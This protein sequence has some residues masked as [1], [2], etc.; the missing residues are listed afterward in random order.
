MTD[1]PAEWIQRAASML[2]S[3]RHVVALTGAGISTPSGI[4]DF[5]S[6]GTGEWAHVDPME[7]VSLSTFRRR[8]ERFYAWLRPLAVKMASAEPNPA[9]LALAELEKAGI[10]HA[11]LTQNIDGLHQKAGSQTVFELHG[12]L[13]TLTASILLKADVSFVLPAIVRAILME[14]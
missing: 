1:L 6:P 10:L 3:A 5:R 14:N 13:R 8:P 12:S 2:R 11:V 7:V 9:H 4:P